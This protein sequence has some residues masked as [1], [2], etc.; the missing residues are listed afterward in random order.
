MSNTEEALNDCNS[1]NSVLGIVLSTEPR[2]TPEFCFH[3]LRPFSPCLV[4]LTLTFLSATF[5]L[6]FKPSRALFQPLL[7]VQ[8]LIGQHGNV[9]AG[10]VHLCK[11]CNLSKLNLLYIKPNMVEF[12][13]LQSQLNGA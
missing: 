6:L 12:T 8:S 10:N 3:Y 2:L 11:A 4:F 13:A 7:R 5:F 1:N 9:T